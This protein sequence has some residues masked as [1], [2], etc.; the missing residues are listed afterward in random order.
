MIAIIPARGGS[1]R[2]PRKNIRLFNGLPIIA[3]AIKTALDSGLFDEVMVSTDDKEI[4]SIAIQYGAKVPF[5]R[6]EETSNDLASTV[7]VIREVITMY[8]Q[9][10]IYFNKVCCIYPCAPFITA[11]L[12]N[13]GFNKLATGNFDSIFPVI[14]YS[15]P[16]Q[17]ALKVVGNNIVMF[18]PEF[19]LTRSQD[20]EPA[21][22][23]A[24]MFYW[25]LTEPILEKGGIMTNK[26]GFIELS[27]M[28]TQDIDNETDWE[29]AEFKYSLIHSKAIK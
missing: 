2:I 23:D 25:F 4:A 3:Y 21:F 7:D 22:Y 28:N 27:E 29:I 8:N 15:T 17:R 14:R 18:N 11:E 1:K 20:L 10:G 12:L 19:A 26:S 16:I 6:T 9:Q 5:F 24:G 13:E